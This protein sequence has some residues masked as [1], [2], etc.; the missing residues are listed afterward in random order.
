MANKHVIEVPHSRLK[1]EVCKILSKEGYI[2]SVEK[3]GTDPKAM[4]K[5]TIK[6][7]NNES[8]ITDI[9]RISKPGLRQYVNHEKIPIV[10]GGMGMAI[11]ST[12][13]GLM[14]GK[15]AKKKGTGGEL[16]C[17]IW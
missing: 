10:L 4:I 13:M 14:T 16:L 3:T 17:T 2:G 11:L 8:V 1:M 6:F 9:K 12:P 15:D 7:V 5:I